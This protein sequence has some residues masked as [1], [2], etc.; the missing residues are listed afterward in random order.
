VILSPPLSELDVQEM[1]IVVEPTFQRVGFNTGPGATA[2]VEILKLGKLK[3]LQAPVLLL[4][5]NV[6]FA[7]IMKRYDVFLFNAWTT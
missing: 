7:E 6:F 1:S 2:N 4:L 5:S 3:G